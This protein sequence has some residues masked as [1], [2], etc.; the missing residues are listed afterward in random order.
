MDIEHTCTVLS[1]VTMYSAEVEEKKRKREEERKE[2]EELALKKKD[3]RN[4]VQKYD[5]CVGISKK[6]GTS[7]EP[8]K[9]QRIS[10]LLA[11]W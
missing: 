9:C 8:T 1:S 11:G 6:V 4:K 10:E 2:C 5:R 3:V 7:H